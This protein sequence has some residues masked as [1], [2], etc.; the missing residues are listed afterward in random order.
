[1]V[2]EGGVLIGEA[3]QPGRPRVEGDRG[4]DTTIHYERFANLT[5]SCRIGSA[6]TAVTTTF[7]MYHLREK[8]KKR[9]REKRGELSRQEEERGKKRSEISAKLSKNKRQL[10]E[11]TE[12]LEEG[13]NI[14]FR[15]DIVFALYYRLHMYI[16]T[17][18]TVHTYTCSCQLYAV[19]LKYI[20]WKFTGM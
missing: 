5:V 3:Q 7:E 15:G 4:L 18:C 19:F 13:E 8:Y 2:G 11:N 16:C 17:A 9:G 14:I 6:I 10:G 1:V 20:Q 12:E